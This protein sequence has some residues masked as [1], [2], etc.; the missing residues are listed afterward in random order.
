MREQW[1]GDK[2]DLVKW[3]VLLELAK[4]Y[5]ARRIIQVAYLRPSKWGLLEIDNDPLPIPIPKEVIEHFRSLR[6]IRKLTA[7]P[8]IDVIDTPFKNRKRYAQ[9]IPKAIEACE[10]DRCIVFLDPDTGIAPNNPTLKHVL[11]PELSDIWKKM[12]RQDDV[13]VL[14]QHKPMYANGEGWIQEK[15]AQF[16]D[17]LGFPQ[18]TSKI[19]KGPT[20]ARDVVFFFCQKA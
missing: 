15:Q 14:Y 4:K 16:E 1:Y 3:G 12:M 13:L 20:I 19:A 5:K 8:R 6:N 9:E 10:K 2:R 7:D 17:A 11:K 18:G